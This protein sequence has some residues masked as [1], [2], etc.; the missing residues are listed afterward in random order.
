MNEL[1]QA[2]Q[3][4]KI[5]SEID[6]QP[7]RF[8]IRWLR[9]MDYSVGSLPKDEITLFK[10]MLLQD[11]NGLSDEETEYMINDRLSF[12][13]F[14]GLKPQESAPEVGLIRLFKEQIGQGSMIEFL[15]EMFNDQLEKM[16]LEKIAI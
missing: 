6:W 13:R 8:M 7:L 10:A 15:F 3:L 12:R 4:E 5:N 9:E 16:G 2:R 14:L 11:W 1:Q